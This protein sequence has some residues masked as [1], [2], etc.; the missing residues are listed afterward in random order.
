MLSVVTGI[1]LTREAKSRTKVDETTM[2][3]S[4]VQLG[5]RYGTN[6]EYIPPSVLGHQIYS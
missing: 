5:A 1:G 6:T 3:I 2:G 4:M